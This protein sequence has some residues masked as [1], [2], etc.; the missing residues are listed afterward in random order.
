MSAIPPAP[1]RRATPKPASKFTTSSGASRTNFRLGLYGPEGIGKTSLARLCPGIEMVNV[2]NS[3]QYPDT[4]YVNGIHVAGDYA[5]S[6]AN[7]RAWAQSLDSGVHGIDSMTRAEDWCTAWVIS[8]KKSNE[9]AKATDSLEDFKYKAGL[10]F[11]VDEFRR[12]ISD[13]DNAYLRGASFVMIAHNRVGKFKNPDG[14]DYMRN[15]PRLIDDAKASNMLQWVQFLDHLLFI[16]LDKNIAKGKVEGS[17]SRTIFLDTAPNRISKT[18]SLPKDP[19]PF[20]EGSTT[21]WDILGV[22]R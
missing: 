12:L 3:T 19:I 14:S 6:W 5:A 9:G 16:D 11:I 4:R 1:V 7:L 22:A 2:E 13:I 15:E 18:R 21:L 10:T 17:G 8:N 20:I